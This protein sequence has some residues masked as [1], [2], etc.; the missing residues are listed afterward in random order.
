M[1]SEDDI[2]GAVVVDFT[3]KRTD[4]V[5][6][7]FDVVAAMIRADELVGAVVVVITVA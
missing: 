6:R 4:E 3:M 7:A 2:V 5:A 1:T